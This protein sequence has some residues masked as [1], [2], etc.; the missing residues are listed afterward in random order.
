MEP[1]PGVFSLVVRLAANGPLVS[2]IV[3]EE[4]TVVVP[5]T[6]D[7]VLAAHPVADHRKPSFAERPAKLPGPPRTTW[8]PENQNRGPGQLQPLV[9][10]CSPATN[11]LRGLALDFLTNA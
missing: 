2:A 6:A 9:S 8:T 5:A 11:G 4:Q 10:P 1:A 3:V 7:I